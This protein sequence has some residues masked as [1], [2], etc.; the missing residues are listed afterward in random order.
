[1]QMSSIALKAADRKLEIQ[2]PVVFRCSYSVSDERSGK[3]D[4]SLTWFLRSS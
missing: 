2:V 1:M 4:T 3:T